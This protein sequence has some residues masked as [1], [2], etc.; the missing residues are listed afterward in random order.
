ML[1]LQ[2]ILAAYLEKTPRI[3]IDS[4]VTIP[5]SSMVTCLVTTPFAAG[6]FQFIVQLVSKYYEVSIKDTGYV[7][8]W[9]GLV[10]VLQA[11]CIL[12]WI[13]IPLLK[14]TTPRPFKMA[15][16]RD[17]DLALAKWSFWYLPLGFLALGAA[18]SIIAF[19]LRLLVL[20]IR[21]GYS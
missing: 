21:S 16:T 9:Y 8:T 15:N 5:L 4:G 7:Q 6:V 2:G 11:L 12:P 10:L 1:Q 18:P 14:D 20:A 19:I 13:S 3:L 17:R